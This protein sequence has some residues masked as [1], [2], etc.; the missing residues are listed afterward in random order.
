MHGIVLA[1]LDG[2]DVRGWS[3]WYTRWASREGSR[4]SLCLSLA[5][6]LATSLLG[7]LWPSWRT[8]TGRCEKLWAGC[9]TKDVDICKW[10]LSELK[11]SINSSPGNQWSTVRPN[12]NISE[13]VMARNRRQS[14]CSKNAKIFLRVMSEFLGPILPFPAKDQLERIFGYATSTQISIWY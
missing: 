12:D 4:A 14:G 6:C 3:T 2:C 13:A 11:K 10:V 9:H 1:R 7:W 8:L 5:P